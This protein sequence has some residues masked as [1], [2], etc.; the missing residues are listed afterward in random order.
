MT[1]TAAGEEPE[2]A[3]LTEPLDQ[4]QLR[5][6]WR[7]QA[8]EQVMFPLEMKNMPVKIGRERQLFLDNYLVAES[9][10]VARQVHHPKRYKDNPVLAPPKAELNHMVVQHVLQFDNP[11]RFR[12]WYWSYDGWQTLPSGQQICFATSYATSND[13]TDWERPNLDLHKVEGLAGPNNVVVPYGMTQ[14]IFYNAD[15]P[16]AEK[17][18]KA[19]VCVERKNPVVREGYYVHTSPDGIHWKGDLSRPVIPSLTG[20]YAI[21]QNGI[22]DTTRFWWDPIRRK[23]I[24]DVKFVIYGRQRCRGVME[25]DDLIH[26]TRPRPTFL[27]RNDDAQ[28]YGHRGFAYQGMYI[29]MRW[30]FLPSYSRRHSSYVELDCSR[31]GRIWTRVAA[32]QPFMAFNPKHDTWDASIMRPV[33]MLEVGDEIWIY[34][35]AAPTELETDNPKYP[36]SAPIDWSV[37]LAKLPRDRFASIN[38]GDKIGTLITRPVDFQGSR[39]HVNAAVAQGGELRVGVLTHEGKPISGYRAADCVPIHGDGIDLPVSWK[40]K[41]KLVG[42]DH[43]QVRFR[44]QLKNAKLFSFWID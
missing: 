28:I 4:N 3:P 42:L 44:F 33:S 31:D 5:I 25:S 29:G 16:D 20:P 19:L 24:G 32:G 26:W 41:A 37:G 13:G 9:E 36:K 23:Y 7:N 30:I 8:N 22:G 14:G 1:A 18:F 12:M 35:F 11:P 21:P 17:R 27:A 38:A 43:F 39:L 34:Y 40:A 15:E 2:G 6:T 10:N